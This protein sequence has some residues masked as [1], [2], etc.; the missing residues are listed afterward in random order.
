[1]GEEEN[2]KQQ[3]TQRFG[4]LSDK[5]TVQRTRR[6]F[7]IV[8]ANNFRQ[9]F[10]YAIKELGFVIL[11]TITGLDEGPTLGFIYHL[12]R[13]NGIILNLHVSVPKENPVIQ[14]VTAHF[15]AADAYERE[16]VDLLGAQVEGLPAGNRYPLPDDWPAG[17]Y[18]LRKDWKGKVSEIKPVS[19]DSSAKGETSPIG[20]QASR[21]VEVKENA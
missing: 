6:I 17:Q 3:L 13:E 5:I 16:L 8:P 15:P 4:F 12:A 9:V 21:D 11:C 1:M 18:P 19:P 14:T 10:E 7:A 2:I 20:G